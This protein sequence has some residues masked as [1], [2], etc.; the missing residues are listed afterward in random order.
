[1]YLPSRLAWSC[2]SAVRVAVCGGLPGLTTVVT[3]SEAVILLLVIMPL[4][5]LVTSCLRFENA[6]RL[7]SS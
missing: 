1:M 6:R 5:L 4:A 7:E 2:V 3:L